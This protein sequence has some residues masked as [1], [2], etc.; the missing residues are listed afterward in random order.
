MSERLQ[1][2]PHKVTA[3]LSGKKGERATAVIEPCCLFRATKFAATD[4]LGGLATKVFPAF[5]GNLLQWKGNFDVVDGQPAWTRGI[6]SAKVN[7]GAFGLEKFDA[8]GHELFVITINVEFLES[9]EWSCVLKGEAFKQP[10][11]T[12]GDLRARAIRKAEKEVADWPEDQRKSYLDGL[13]SRWS[14]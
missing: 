6:V 1:L 4:S 5:V 13:R 8:V 12:I 9:C 3:S 10:G 14:P 7:M 11:D 2:L